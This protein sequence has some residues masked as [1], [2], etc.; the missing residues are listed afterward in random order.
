M[1]LA[2]LLTVRITRLSR[3]RPLRGMESRRIRFDTQLVSG[4]CMQYDRTALQLASE[5]GHGEVV[6]ALLRVGAEVN[7][8]TK[9]RCTLKC[10]N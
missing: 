10:L 6:E 9:V 4:A 1:Q 7:C 3:I 2:T 5:Y 8:K